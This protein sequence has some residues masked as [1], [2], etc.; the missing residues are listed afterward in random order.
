MVQQI[1]TSQDSSLYELNI[2][3]QRF[4]SNYFSDD[5]TVIGDTDSEDIEIEILSD[6]EV[7]FYFCFVFKLFF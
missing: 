4:I 5:I 6:E 3:A 2:L 1:E 7:S